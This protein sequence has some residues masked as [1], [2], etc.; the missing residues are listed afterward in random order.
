MNPRHLFISRRVMEGKVWRC[1]NERRI[2]ITARCHVHCMTFHQA[3]VSRRCV[4]NDCLSDAWEKYNTRR[5][6]LRCGPER[7]L[8]R[9]VPQIVCDLMILPSETFHADPVFGKRHKFACAQLLFPLLGAIAP[10]VDVH[11]PMC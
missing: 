9:F 7:H 3:K 4:R 2:V 8:D 1:G 10:Q 6:N 11:L 5:D